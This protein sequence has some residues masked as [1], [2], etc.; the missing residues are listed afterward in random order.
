MRAL[1][2]QELHSSPQNRRYFF[3]RFSGK[4][5]PPS[6]VS[7]DPLPLHARENAKNSAFSAGIEL[8]G[9]TAANVEVRRLPKKKK[10]KPCLLS[11][12]TMI[13]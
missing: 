2:K 8:H 9:T 7:R 10:K 5:L 11:S 12:R 4:R 6:R 13:N 1:W 3:S